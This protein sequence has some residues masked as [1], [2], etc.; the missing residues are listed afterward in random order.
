[1]KA[2]VTGSGAN[3]KIGTFEKTTE[4][5]RLNV[6]LYP[7]FLAK[8]FGTVE[9]YRNGLHCKTT[10]GYDRITNS[11]EGFLHSHISDSTRDLIF[12]SNPLDSACLT[13]LTKSEFKNGGS[14]LYDTYAKKVFSGFPI[15]GSFC[16]LFQPPFSSEINENGRS[17][18]SSIL[19]YY[20]NKSTTIKLHLNQN[21]N[22]SFNLIGSD[23]GHVYKMEIVS[24]KLLL[25]KLRFDSGIGYD[26]AAQKLFSSCKKQRLQMPSMIHQCFVEPIAANSTMVHKQWSRI[27]VPSKLVLFKIDPQLVTGGSPEP[28]SNTNIDFWKAMDVSDV[29]ISFNGLSLFDGDKNTFDQQKN[30]M[31]FVNIGRLQQSFINNW[32]LSEKINNTYVQSPDNL[33]PCMIFNFNLWNDPHSKISPTLGSSTQ[34]QSPGA[35]DIKLNFTSTTTVTQGT[36]AFFFIYETSFV[37]LEVGEGNIVNPLL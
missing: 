2:P 30:L 21:D 37:S 16:K 28:Y 18:K 23:K 33:W 29:S 22:C 1:M 32:K 5:D 15:Y 7:N 36:L 8:R 24:I 27:K 34:L 6:Q 19:P 14:T 3:K 20:E 12:G 17:L 35:F 13:G 31:S 26:L 4:A 10:L 25:Y 11:F 9:L